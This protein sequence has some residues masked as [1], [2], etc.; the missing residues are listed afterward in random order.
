MIST[1]SATFQHTSVPAPLIVQTGEHWSLHWAVS[2]RAGGSM[3]STL[4]LTELAPLVPRMLEILI[5]IHDTPIAG[6]AG[7]GWMTETGDAVHSSWNDFL[8]GD[9]TYGGLVDWERAMSQAPAHQRDLI[10]ESWTIAGKLMDHGPEERV[11]NHGD[12]SLANMLADGDRITGVVDWS[13]ING[14]PVWDVAWADFWAP[15]L[16][17]A[18][19]YFQAKPTD[20]F[21]Q[22]LMCYQLLSAAQSLGF[23]IHTGQ[24]AKG[25]WLEGPLAR[26]LRSAR[27]YR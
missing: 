20:G 14:D 10:E 26:L 1:T 7:Y 23:Y 12:Y 16:G 22:R 6:T 13:Y 15:D 24:P 3:L 8:T 5:A 2:E 9:G 25:R 21:D 27:A 17:F 19:E 18:A 4:P 11:L